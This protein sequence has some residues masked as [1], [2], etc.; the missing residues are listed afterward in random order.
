MDTPFPLINKQAAR[1]I[2][3]KHT[4][5]LVSSYADKI[6][7][8]VSQYGKVGSIVRTSV[9]NATL[10]SI[11]LE[12]LLQKLTCTHRYSDPYIYR[13]TVSDFKYGCLGTGCND[14]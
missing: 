14:L 13:P 1:T 12:L 3:G 11:Q 7:I 10:A 8:L 5:V 6:L 2:Q 9:G 4:E